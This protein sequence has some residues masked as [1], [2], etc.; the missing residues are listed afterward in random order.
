MPLDIDV[1][2]RKVARTTMGLARSSELVD[3]GIGSS[4][5]A[6]RVTRGVWK[7]PQRGVVDVTGQAWTWS[8]RV[9]AAVLTCPPGSLASHR[10]AAG[11][12]DLPGMR[13]A[14]R[15]EVTTPRSG[16]T[17]DVAFTV[18]STLHPDQG[19]DLDGIPVTRGARTAFDLAT[20]L[21]DRRFARVTRE[22][23]RRGDLL[24]A[25]VHD[26]IL[27]HLPG[28]RRLEACIDRE[29]DNALHRT[30]SVLEDDVVAWLLEH[31][32]D[33]FVTQHEVTVD[34]EDY[35]LDIAWREAMVVVEVLGARWHADALAR[36]AD[37]ERRRQLEEA[38]WTVIPVRAD[39][40]HGAASARLAHRLRTA[41]P[42]LSA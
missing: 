30:E 35:R 13:R 19:T 41:L 29:W 22:L 12:H 18:H 2:A 1:T 14:G 23:L 36:E 20:C 4:T 26:P 33:G 15:I 5:I 8:R 38:G 39:D 25:D 32:F 16:R 31:G 3:A 11:L 37:A 10:T 34:E 40:L 42:A 6:R 9:L 24:P 7:R 27:R 21:D 28:R 17:R